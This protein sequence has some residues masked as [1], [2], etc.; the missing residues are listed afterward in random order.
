MKIEFLFPE[1]VTLYG[2]K[3]NVEYLAKCLPQARLV[4]TSL[5]EGPAFAIPEKNPAAL[6]ELKGEGRKILPPELC[7]IGSMEEDYF[8]AALESLRPYKK[9]LEKYIKS[10]RILLATGNAIDLFGKKI[11]WKDRVYPDGHIADCTLEGLGLFDMVSVVRRDQT[12]HN[13]WY[14]GEFENIKIL[15]HRSTFSRQYGGSSDPF[16]TTLGGFGMNDETK[17]EGVHRDGFYGTTL[18]GPLLIMNPELTRYFI[19]KMCELS[20][21]KAPSELFE[22]KLI[23]EAYH[24]RLAY[25][26]KPDARYAMGALG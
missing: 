19:G 5:G 25:L 10:G 15:G 13:S 24:N 9:A 4:T 21:E 16:I 23:M 2:E 14:Y 3:A 1:L 12:R 22:E 11:E 20:G 6:P 8:E 18:L 17:Q 26:S 7:Y